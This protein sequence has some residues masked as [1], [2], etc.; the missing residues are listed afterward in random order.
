MANKIYLI[1]VPSYPLKTSETYL[2]FHQST[3]VFEYLKK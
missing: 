3:G 1:W 2:R